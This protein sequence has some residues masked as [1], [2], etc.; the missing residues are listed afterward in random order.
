MGPCPGWGPRTL[1]GKA[2]LT[3][4]PSPAVVCGEGAKADPDGRCWGGGKQRGAGRGSAWHGGQGTVGCSGDDPGS[5]QGRDPHGVR[6]HSTE[7]VCLA[8]GD[9]RGGN[10]GGAGPGLQDLPAPHMASVGA[11]GGGPPLPPR[12]R[13]CSSRV[14]PETSSPRTHP[15]HRSP[16]P[17]AFLL[18]CKGRCSLRPRGLCTRLP[19]SGAPAPLLGAPAPV[20]SAV[21]CREHRSPLSGALSCQPPCGPV[22]GGALVSAQTAAP[23]QPLTRHSQAPARLSPSSCFL[24]RRHEL[25]LCLFPVLVR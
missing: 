21:P 17:L 10:P 9:A 3:E 6:P 23:P 25:A 22:P 5:C 12:R 24:P 15:A 20:G 1:P 7:Q 14:S 8:W 2:S 13:W 16:G 18:P 19:L 11:A 4:G